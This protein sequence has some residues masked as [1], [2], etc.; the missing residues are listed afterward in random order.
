MLAKSKYISLLRLLIIGSCSAMITV[1]ALTMESTA[2]TGSC[3]YSAQ[4][5]SDPVLRAE[6]AA[7]INDPERLNSGTEIDGFSTGCLACHDGVTATGFNLRI[8]NNPQNR[9]T[10]IE[11]IIGG[12]PVGMHYENYV[13]V[14]T[15][16]YNSNVDFSG[17][18]IF[19]AGRVGCLTC[20]NPLNTE[21]G[22]LSLTNENSKLCFACHRI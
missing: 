2:E 12:H 22:H 11:D 6:Y 7:S 20:H 5:A 16:S 15:D 3:L 1:A 4:L 21:T 13:A 8:K 17:D 14:K 18:M 10:S 9:A 19:A